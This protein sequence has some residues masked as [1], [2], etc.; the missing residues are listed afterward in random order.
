MIELSE[1]QSKLSGFKVRWLLIISVAVVLGL[2]LVL[3]FLLTQATDNRD[4][5]ERNYRLL[6]GL[7]VVVASLLMA[8]IAWFAVR[9]GQVINLQQCGVGVRA[10]AAARA[11]TWTTRQH[12]LSAARW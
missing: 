2:S 10:W 8:V 12:A 7:N 5:Y 6:F 1:K 11:H 4:L 3:L 9:L